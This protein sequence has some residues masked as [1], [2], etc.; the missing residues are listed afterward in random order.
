[1]A[2]FNG[3]V[4]GHTIQ[5]GMVQLQSN[6]YRLRVMVNPYA[7]ALVSRVTEQCV[8]K[9]EVVSRVRSTSSK[10]QISTVG[11]GPQKDT[12]LQTS[13]NYIATNRVV[14]VYKLTET[15]DAK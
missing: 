10:I 13:Y 5:C 12:T 15:L 1:M 11:V 6:S 8:S 2:N 9:P 4:Y 7:E 3:I 14:T